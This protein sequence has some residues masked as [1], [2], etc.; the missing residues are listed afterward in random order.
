LGRLVRE[1]NSGGAWTARLSSYVLEEWDA[2]G[3][4]TRRIDRR[5]PWFQPY[6]RSPRVT[7]DTAP[8]PVLRD[9]LFRSDRLLWVMINYP[10]D[11]YARY[12][13]ASQL[14]SD[15][16]GYRMTRADKLR[17]TVVEVIDIESGRVLVTRRFSPMFLGFLDDHHVYSYAEDDLGA[18]RYDVWRIEFTINSRST[19]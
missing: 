17:N 11:D 12:L 1:S 13:E 5:V 2:N 18:G 14:T 15:I 8:A 16:V 7:P 4:R 6:D 10:A 3:N 9:F 19:S